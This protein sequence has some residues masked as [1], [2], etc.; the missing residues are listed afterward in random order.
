MNTKRLELIC[1]V[2]AANRLRG[3]KLVGKS[4]FEKELEEWIN[5]PEVKMDLTPDTLN[6]MA[7]LGVKKG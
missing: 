7:I 5:G 6:S 4:A 1:K 3:V 2:L